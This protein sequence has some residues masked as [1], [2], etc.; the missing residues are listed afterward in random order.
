MFINELHY[1][2]LGADVGEAVELAGLSGT[3]LQGWRLWFY[4][5]GSGQS[6]GSL[7]LG[8]VFADSQNGAGVLAFS[9][10]GIQNGSPDGIALTN[11]TNQIQQFISYE[12]VFSALAGVAKNLLSENIGIVE[13]SVTAIGTSLQLTGSGGASGDF[14]WRVG[15]GSFGSV[16]AL[17]QFNSER[18]VQGLVAS[19]PA[20][21]LLTLGSLGIAVSGKDEKGVVTA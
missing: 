19:V 6:Y 5:G 3:N 17:Q 1:D 16:N 18:G 10:A 11:A 9:F 7:A 14:Q 20:W 4:N 15:A 21:T 12:G 2:N 13:S 8:G